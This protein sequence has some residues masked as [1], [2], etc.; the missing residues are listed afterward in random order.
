MFLIWLSSSIDSV[1]YVTRHI[2]YIC[3]KRIKRLSIQRILNLNEASYIQLFLSISEYSLRSIKHSLAYPC[4][5][6]PSL[7]ILLSQIR[8]SLWIHYLLILR[9]Y[10]LIYFL[11]QICICW[12]RF[13]SS[14]GDIFILF[15]NICNDTAFNRAVPI[16][17]V[18]LYE[19]PKKQLL[20]LQHEILQKLVNLY[21]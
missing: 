21:N 20:T 18:I 1:F 9:I 13:K 16:K 4:P 2:I 19:S 8:L 15:W 10:Y 5:T 3:S 6:S 17:E 11:F 14:G 7:Y 12:A